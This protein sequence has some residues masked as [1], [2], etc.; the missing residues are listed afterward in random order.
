MNEYI[1]SGGEE[2]TLDVV[3]YDLIPVSLVPLRVSLSLSDKWADQ[4][5]VK[6]GSGS[7]LEPGLFMHLLM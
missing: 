2:G 5:R 3:Y 7:L 1:E 6:V 4:T